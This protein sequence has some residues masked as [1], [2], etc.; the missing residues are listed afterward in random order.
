MKKCR[1][2]LALLLVAALCGGLL[3]VGVFA[4]GEASGDASGEA[5]A[6][7]SAIDLTGMLALEQYVFVASQGEVENGLVST[8]VY[9]VYAAG[10]ED[11]PAY[12]PAAFD[13]DIA[14]YTDSAMTEAAEGVDAAVSGGTLT[15]TGV[16]QEGNAVYYLSTDPDG[17]PTTIYVVNDEYAENTAVL[18]LADGSAITLTTYAPN[19]AQGDYAAI[20]NANE[21]AGETSVYIGANRTARSVEDMTDLANASDE[22][23][24]VAAW[25]LSAGATNSGSTIT[26]FGEE[27]YN[28]E[29]VVALYRLFQIVNEQMTYASGF[30]DA[31]DYVGG[32][33]SNDQFSDAVSAT[34]ASGIWNGIY[35]QY[36]D[37][38][39]PTA[40][41]TTATGY[42]LENIDA[43]TTE[44]GVNETATVNFVYVGLYNAFQSPWSSLSQE[45]E[46]MAVLLETAA[47]QYDGEIRTAPDDYSNEA[48]IHAVASVVMGS[49]SDPAGDEALS[50]LEALAVLYA[51]RNCVESV[52]FAD[53]TAAQAVGS[54]YADMTQYFGNVYT[55]EGQIDGGVVADSDQTWL[56]RASYDFE[57]TTFG[58]LT[59]GSFGASG[60]ALTSTL[61]GVDGAE[62]A[63]GSLGEGVGVIY[64]ATFR[65][66][67]YREA[68]GSGVAIVGADTLV[69][70]TS[71]DGTLVLSGSGGSMAGTA[72]VGFGASL[73]ISNTVAY[74]SSQHLT[75]NLYNGTIHYTDAAAFGSGRLYSSDFWGG[76]Q[77]FED[78]VA[79]GGNVTDEPTTLV[80][81][82]SVY[83]N[84]VGGN[85]FASQ[86]FENAVLNV[87]SAS[88]HNTTS[89]ITDTG[90]LTFV[91][92]VVNNSGSSVVSASKGENVILTVVDSAISMPGGNTLASLDASSTI[93]HN[94]ILGT[95]SDAYDALF[96]SE[97]AVYFY[98]DSTIATSDGT[99]HATVAE[100]ATLYVY[101]ANLTEADIINDGDGEIVVV[102]DSAYGTVEV[103]E[104]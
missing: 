93:N 19:M 21:I 66:A 79:T 75:N 14:V 46:A 38:L 4:S 69:T 65:N 80:V 34:M 78:T 45:G 10:A 90:S 52:S 26:S 81:K 28:F 70:M 82:N 18:T 43:D 29:Y 16:A 84:S 6:G 57:N 9:G 53:E 27:L 41:G 50:K 91:N 36:S 54:S 58:T 96:N 47:A 101:S 86:Y 25:W 99:L 15:V 63:T 92:S 76:Y 77:V 102:T 30:V 37:T 94:A 11:G 97:I 64:N 56:I 48:K 24:A 35:S 39:L 85:G 3:G 32:M 103:L 88:F 68:I 98:G 7:A 89:L 87:G 5:S 12:E 72:Y 74:S 33:G 20:P 62:A 73:S 100:G 55:G 60:A 95:V 17:Y 83:G 67:Y 42:L 40:E 59:E 31:A 44:L 1:S 71:D 2:I 22:E 51:V 23:L 61:T 8:A 13:G 104:A 49:D